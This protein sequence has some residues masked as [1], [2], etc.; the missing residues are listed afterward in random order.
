MQECGFL[1]VTLFTDIIS[2]IFSPLLFGLLGLFV[3]VT[4]TFKL[5]QY[6][7][8]PETLVTLP[9]SSQCNVRFARLLLLTRIRLP[10]GILK[11][12]HFLLNLFQD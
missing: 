8:T 5:I 7:V 4:P 12:S 6:Q 2:I 9:A 3:F 1:V 11:A 10:F